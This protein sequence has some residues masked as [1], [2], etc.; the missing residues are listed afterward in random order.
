MS[1]KWARLSTLTLL[2]NVSGALKIVPGNCYCFRMRKGSTGNQLILANISHLWP[3]KKKEKSPEVCIFMT[4][5]APVSPLREKF[6]GFSH[7]LHAFSHDLHGSLLATKILPWRRFLWM[8][9][10][11]EEL[12][13]ID[14]G[15]MNR[16]RCGEEAF[17]CL[18]KD[19]NQC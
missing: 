17:W 16:F 10:A 4:V 18:K 1:L 11:D 5:S 8:Q 9:K 2:P 3:I 12:K 15:A 6:L 7:D 14:S 19:R 13:S